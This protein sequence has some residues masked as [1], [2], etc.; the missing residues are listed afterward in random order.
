MR[1]VLEQFI[2]SFVFLKKRLI[3]LLGVVAAFFVL[4][5]VLT[6]FATM[7]LPELAMQIFNAISEM[8]ASSGILD[9]SGNISALFLFFSNARAGFTGIIWGFMPFIFLPLIAVFING[10]IIGVT[11]GIYGLMTEINPLVLLAAGIL[12][13]GI[14]ELTAI[15]LCWA[16]GLGICLLLTKKIF[17]AKTDVS[18]SY[19]IKRCLGVYLF[20]VIPLLIVA[21]VVESYVTP[22]IM[23]MVIA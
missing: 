15:F 14:F 8:M 17:G 12:P 23:N 20:F 2:M 6:Y 22:V 13:H 5:C 16:M 11:L 19:Y 7:A 21:A 4:I 9:E 3:K 1:F 10:A 18:F